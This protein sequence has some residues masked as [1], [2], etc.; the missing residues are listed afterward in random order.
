MSMAILV[1]PLFGPIFNKSL[2]YKVLSTKEWLMA[3]GV[4]R[5]QV[6]VP[7]DPNLSHYLEIW[8]KFQTTL[9][10]TGQDFDDIGKSK[11]WL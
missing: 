2:N 6:L 5:A 9:E 11:N 3:H 8:D 4:W 1:Q 10:R 7:P